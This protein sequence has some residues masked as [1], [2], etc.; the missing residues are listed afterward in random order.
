MFCTINVLCFVP[1]VTNMTVEL[2]L[3]DTWR[4]IW[5]MN[6]KSKNSKVTPYGN[7]RA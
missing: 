5:L 4:N 1:Y 6:Q 7:R 2:T 3:G